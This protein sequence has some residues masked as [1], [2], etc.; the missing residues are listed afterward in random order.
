MF[1]RFERASGKSVKCSK[2]SSWS[3]NETDGWVP[4]EYEE[5][6]GGE[7]VNY[8]R[9]QSLSVIKPTLY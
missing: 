4:A 6:M 3:Y 2:L 1:L 9:K 8:R 5:T 7:R